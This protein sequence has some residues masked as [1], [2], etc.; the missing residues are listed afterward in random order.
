[1]FVGVRNVCF[2][3]V[4]RQMLRQAFVA[5]LFLLAT[6]ML[7][8]DRLLFWLFEPR[9][10]DRLSQTF[11]SIGR[12]VAKINPQLIRIV[13]ITFATPGKRPGDQL[14]DLELEF[15]LL[16]FEFFDLQFK[17]LALAVKFV[18][19]VRL[20]FDQ[21]GFFVD[22]AS[23]FVDHTGLFV[24]QRLTGGQIVGDRFSLAGSVMHVNIVTF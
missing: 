12:V 10:V 1:M 19:R 18:D 17:R 4:T 8:N 7:R 3:F 24:D 6:N 14:F 20:R 23:L 22:R 15:F 11:S 16:L 2:D 13:Q 21:A 9:L 5:T